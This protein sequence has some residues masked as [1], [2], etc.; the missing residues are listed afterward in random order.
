RN[1]HFRFII[2]ICNLIL[3]LAIINTGSRGSLLGLMGGIAVYIIHAS[4]QRRNT[5][6]F[7]ILTV[8]A[9]YLIPAKLFEDAIYNVAKIRL[10]LSLQ[11]QID[12]MISRQEI[13]SFGLKEALNA[14]PF[15]VGLGDIDRSLGLHM[16]IWGE[17]NP[18]NNLLR[19]IADTGLLGLFLFILMYGKLIKNIFSASSSR[20]TVEFLAGLSFLTLMFIHGL[21]TEVQFHKPFWLAILITTIIINSNQNKSHSMSIY[22]EIKNNS[23]E[24]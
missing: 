19:W 16:R 17:I 22:K 7:I 8:L 9:L 13:L 21:F 18:H 2:Y 1:K 15:G 12:S 3:L 24:H 4:K 11:Q 6:V 5:M 23:R 20:L 14:L 10:S